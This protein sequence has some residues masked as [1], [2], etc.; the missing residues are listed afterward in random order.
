MLLTVSHS[1]DLREP[2]SRVRP[3]A[4][5]LTV[6]LLHPLTKAGGE[7]DYSHWIILG[8]YNK[9]GDGH[10]SV[11]VMFILYLK[12][13]NRCFS[14]IWAWNTLFCGFRWWILL[15]N[16]QMAEFLQDTRKGNAVLFSQ[17]GYYRS[18][19]LWLSLSRAEPTSLD[20]GWRLPARLD[21]GTRGR[22]EGINAPKQEW[23]PAK[24]SCKGS[25]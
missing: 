22:L 24:D 17:P 1:S 25:R 9:M 7:A 3:N 4:M 10:G 16:V 12:A 11:C 23:S 20:R 19:M 13:D 18:V 8:D 5:G 21:A 14:H 15:R 6:F 2:N